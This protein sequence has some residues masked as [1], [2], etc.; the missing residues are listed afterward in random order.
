VSGKLNIA[1]DETIGFEDAAKAKY[2]HEELR[3][4]ELMGIHGGKHARTAY[5]TNL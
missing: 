4:A 2:D 3:E 5:E 1:G